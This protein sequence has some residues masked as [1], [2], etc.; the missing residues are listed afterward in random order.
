MNLQQAKMSVQS[1]YL[2]ARMQ[3]VPEDRLELLRRFMDDCD[4][5]ADQAMQAQQEAMQAQQ[6]AAQPMANPQLPPRSDL[7]PLAPQG[8]V[9]QA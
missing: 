2:K 1:A 9:P 5:L 7:L 3:Y 6:A 8:V 4:A